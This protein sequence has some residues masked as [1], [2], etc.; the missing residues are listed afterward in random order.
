ML[1]VSNIVLQ[2]CELLGTLPLDKPPSEK[3]RK[4]LVNALVAAFPEAS[5]RMATVARVCKQQVQLY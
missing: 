4:L 1:H 2:I 3:N 5:K